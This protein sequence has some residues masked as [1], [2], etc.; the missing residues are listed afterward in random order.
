VDR[1]AVHHL[2]EQAAERLAALGVPPE[3][4]VIGIY[5]QFSR[6]SRVA[7]QVLRTLLEP[8]S[9]RILTAVPFAAGMPTAA[10]AGAGGP[11][12]LDLVLDVSRLP[13]PQARTIA[14]A[15]GVP[16]ITRPFPAMPQVDSGP[17]EGTPLARG[18]ATGRAMALDRRGITTR[19]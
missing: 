4:A 5:R 2:A 12:R 18:T 14:D 17:A 10:P 19:V 9:C 1:D 11:G 13:H 6:S 8:A 15:A 16:L 7:A 3:E